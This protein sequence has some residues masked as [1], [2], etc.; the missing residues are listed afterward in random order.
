MGPGTRDYESLIREAGEWGPW[1]WRMMAVMRVPAMT[2]GAATLSWVFTARPVSS[3]CDGNT[4]SVVTDH[5][6]LLADL[7]LVCEDGWIVSV[8]APVFMLGMLV[9]GP[10][11][12]QLSDR[13]GRRLGLLLSLVMVTMSGALQPALP[14]SLAW[15]LAWRLGA[16]LGAGGVLVTTFVYL[17]EWPT[18]GP[19]G[20]AGSWRLVAA[21]GL[22]LGWNTGQALLLT[23]AS[24][25]TD[26]RALHWIAHSTG[27]LAICLV[28]TQ[29]E[30][31][32]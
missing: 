10:L 12:G 23:S 20:A 15:A 29:P 7:D 3:A 28:L 13:H 22:H 9:G 31:A 25:L 2:A 5:G 17:I 1:Q 11:A 4:S 14:H 19:A 16:G 32:R 6:S 26:W 21:L 24:L 8:L 30:S 27:L 18:A